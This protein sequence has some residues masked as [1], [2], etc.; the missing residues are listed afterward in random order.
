MSLHDS[1]LDDDF[2]GEFGWDSRSKPWVKIAYEVSLKS[3]EKKKMKKKTKET[4]H[5]DEGSDEPQKKVVWV[6]NKE[7]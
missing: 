5:V 6:A 3:E 2:D 7:V 4:L 1:P